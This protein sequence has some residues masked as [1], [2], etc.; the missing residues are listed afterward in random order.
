MVDLGYIT[1]LRLCDLVAKLGPLDYIFSSMAHITFTSL[2]AKFVGVLKS[3]S[4]SFQHDLYETRYVVT[5]CLK[6]IQENLA[7]FTVIK[8]AYAPR[9]PFSFWWK[10]ARWSHLYHGSRRSFCK[11][12]SLRPAAWAA[13][14]P[15]ARAYFFSVLS[16]QKWHWLCRGCLCHR[17]SAIYSFPFPWQNL[18]DFQLISVEKTPQWKIKQLFQGD[19]LNQISL[20]VLP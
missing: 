13:F 4:F 3:I 6:I 14:P 7:F 18:H 9:V 19:I 20:S 5:S 15:V 10:S 2:T 1:S 16:A 17:L 8:Q 11:L 12:I